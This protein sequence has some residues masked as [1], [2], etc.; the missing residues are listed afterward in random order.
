MNCFKSL[1]FKRVLTIL[2][3]AIVLSFMFILTSCSKESASVKDDKEMD[4][5]LDDKGVSQK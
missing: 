4:F 5:H 2:L 1:G 3:G